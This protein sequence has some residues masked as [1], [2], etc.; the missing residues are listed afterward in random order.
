VPLRRWLDS[1]ERLSESAIRRGLRNWK[2][3]G[4]RSSALLRRVT[5]ADQ[6][7]FFGARERLTCRES[8]QTC[9][10]FQIGGHRQIPRARKAALCLHPFS[11]T[12]CALKIP[13][14]PFRSHF[15]HALQRAFLFEQVRCAGNQTQFLRTRHARTSL[16]VQ[17]NH[18]RVIAA[19]D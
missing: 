18:A 10:S 11:R 19:N 6:R 5:R 1:A 7:R 8:F 4:S 12:S 15:C 2:T 13:L 9:R 3:L 16:L 17:F 14:E